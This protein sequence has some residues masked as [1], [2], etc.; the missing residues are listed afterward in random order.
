[1]FLFYPLIGLGGFI[2]LFNPIK[3]VHKK[4]ISN[5]IFIAQESSDSQIGFYK[6][7]IGILESD[8]PIPLTLTLI[9]LGLLNV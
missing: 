7:S 4:N 6:L 3:N 9:V 2:N 8:P 5:N 1:M